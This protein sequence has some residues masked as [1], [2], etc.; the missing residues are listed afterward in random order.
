MSG[1]RKNTHANAADFHGA[2]TLVKGFAML[3]AFRVGDCYL[4]NNNIAI[5]TGFSQPTVSRLAGTMLRLGYL[6]YSE[7]LGKYALSTP[8][9]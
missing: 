1:R 8:S 4:G 3:R 6:R 9:L 2:Q 5:R 7:S